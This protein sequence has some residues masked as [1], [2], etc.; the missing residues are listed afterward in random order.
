MPQWQYWF[1]GTA[2]ASFLGLAA[3]VATLGLNWYRSAVQEA[4]SAKHE[5]ETQENRDRTEK[6]KS[7]LVA[8]LYRSNDLLKAITPLNIAESDKATDEWGE[9]TRDLI[10]GAYG[11]SEAALFL[12]N[13]GYT[14]YG[15][16]SAASNMKNWVDG[17]QRRLTELLARASTLLVKKEF[18]AAKFENGT[19]GAQ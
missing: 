11:E 3:A 10:R 5:I 12:N 13:S 9:H 16:G 19:Q 2:L 8:A 18:D 17:R 7:L 15:D 14:F 6:I 4:E 1:T